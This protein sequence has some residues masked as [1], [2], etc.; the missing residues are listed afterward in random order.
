[1]RSLMV[2]MFGVVLDH[3]LEVRRSEYDHPVKAL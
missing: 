1:V 3:M 2:I